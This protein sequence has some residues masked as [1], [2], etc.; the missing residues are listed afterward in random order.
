MIKKTALL[1]MSAASAVSVALVF[2]SS[3][4]SRG[5][6]GGRIS[7]FTLNQSFETARNP[8]LDAGGDDT[9][10]TANTDLGY[11]LTSETR[12]STIALS[13]GLR[14][15]ASSG[16]VAASEEGFDID[17][18]SVELSYSTRAPRVD[19]RGS[20]GISQQDLAFATAVDLIETVDGTLVLPEDIGDLDGRGTRTRSFFRFNA[21]VDQEQPFGWAMTLSGTQ[22]TFSDTTSADL[23]DTFSLFAALDAHF[24][25]T[26]TVR[27]DTRLGYSFSDSDSDGTSSTTSF[28]VGITALRSDTLAVRGGL[29]FSSPDDAGDRLTLTTGLSFEPSSTTALSFDIGATS[30]DGGD[31][32][33]VVEGNYTRQLTR[34]LE[35]NAVVNRS[36][37]DTSDT[38]NV[39]RTVATFGLD[40]ALTPLSSVSFN[41]LFADDD[42]PGTGDDGRE[43]TA[44]VQYNLQLNRDWQMSAG[45]RHTSRDTDTDGSASSEALFFGI[46]RSWSGRF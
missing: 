37:I 3:L 13:L 2:A 26:P 36:V 11:S 43:F 42:A 28:G 18:P 45:L 1:Q 20:I 5:Q 38:D 9:R 14:L 10:F 41:A 16:D 40:Y 6:D 21:A 19:L 30:V 46:G 31:T 17:R 25:L 7:E 4:Q 24:E 15:R 8:V 23:D 39:L 35:V 22:L 29:T 12:S 44:S 33:F 32:S 27:I 34:S